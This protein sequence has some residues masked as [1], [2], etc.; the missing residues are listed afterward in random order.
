MK[1]ELT[2]EA[3]IDKVKK[4]NDYWMAE[5]PESGDSHW[6]RAAYFV[7]IMSAYHMTGDTRYLDFAIKWAND[8]NWDY[9]KNGKSGHI[10][11]P[12]V[13]FQFTHVRDIGLLR[14]H[15]DAFD[16]GVFFLQFFH[17]GD[18]GK[19]KGSKTSKQ[20]FVSTLML[21]K[22]RNDLSKPKPVKLE[23]VH[24]FKKRYFHFPSEIK[25]VRPRGAHRKSATLIVATQ[26]HSNIGYE[27]RV[28]LLP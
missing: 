27:E 21:N 12:W 15:N 10:N 28:H 3:I 20:E 5:N 9:S 1:Y 22:I 7:G 14:K 6:K 16:I 26:S 13:G 11:A 8:N 19:G 18:N 23:I 17:C 4:I 2:K 25:K 24:G